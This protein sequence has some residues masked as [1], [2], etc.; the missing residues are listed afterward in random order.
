[1]GNDLQHD[2]I[3]PGH[4]GEMTVGQGWQVFAVSLWQ[5]LPGKHDLLL[6]EVEVID[7]PFRSGAY[8]F[9]G[10]DI[11]DQQVPHFQESVLIVSQ[12]FEQMIGSA[13]RLQPMQRRYRFPVVV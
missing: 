10:F 4:A 8:G 7:Q 1:M 13:V 3:D 6:Y 12:P 5:V 9:T 11:P 2:V